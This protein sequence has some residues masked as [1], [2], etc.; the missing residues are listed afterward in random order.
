MNCTE[1]NRAQTLRE[2]LQIAQTEYGVEPAFTV[3][4]IVVSG[5]LHWNYEAQVFVGG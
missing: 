1:E 4:M 3:Q 5:I 2:L